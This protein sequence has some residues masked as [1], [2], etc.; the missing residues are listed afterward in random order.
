MIAMQ[1]VEMLHIIYCWQFLFTLKPLPVF[2]IEACM[3]LRTNPSKSVVIGKLLI[4]RQFL[5]KGSI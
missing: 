4:F 3:F 1:S 2:G 5:W